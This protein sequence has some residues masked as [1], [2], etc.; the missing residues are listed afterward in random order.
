[1]TFEDGN[2]SISLARDVEIRCATVSDDV[3]ARSMI[4]LGLVLMNYGHRQAALR[5]LE[6]AKL[7]SMGSIYNLTDVCFSIAFV[8]VD[9]ENRLPEALDAVKEAW[10]N[11]ESRN[12]LVSQAQFSA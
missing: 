7:K 6:R 9:L 3:H 12:D 2:K 11:V 8:C 4:A 5:H 1:L 10:E